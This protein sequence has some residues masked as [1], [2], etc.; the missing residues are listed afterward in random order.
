MYCLGWSS[1]V[2]GTCITSVGY[3]QYV[4]PLLLQ[5]IAFNTWNLCLSLLPQIWRTFVVSTDYFCSVG[6]AFTI[7]LTLDFSCFHYVTLWSSLLI[8]DIIKLLLTQLIALAMRDD[9]CFSYMRLVVISATLFF[10][11]PPCSYVFSA[12]YDFPKSSHFRDPEI[13][14]YLKL[15]LF[16]KLHQRSLLLVQ[17]LLLTISGITNYYAIIN[18]KCRRYAMTIDYM[19]VEACAWERIQQLRS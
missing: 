11:K 12:F 3:L 9:G 5:L 4:E 6:L 1:L 7:S 19:L 10:F 18:Y 17:V 13:D 15:L 2:C 8:A 14:K 16:H